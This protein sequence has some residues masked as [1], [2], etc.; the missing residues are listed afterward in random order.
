MR[1]KIRGGTARSDHP[2]LCLSCRHATVVRGASLRDEIVQ[3]ARLSGGANRITFP[4]IFC[5]GHVDRTHPTHQR[6]G[7][8]GVDP[9]LRSSAQ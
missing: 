6:N 9:A 3:C 4:V 8:N 1:M 7:G 2:S 5:S